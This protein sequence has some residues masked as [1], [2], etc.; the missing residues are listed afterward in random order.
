[1]RFLTIGRM[2][3]LQMGMDG[4]FFKNFFVLFFSFVGFL[5]SVNVVE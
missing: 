1:M 5:E 4:F 2:R 3:F